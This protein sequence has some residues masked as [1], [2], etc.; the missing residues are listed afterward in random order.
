WSTGDT[1]ETTRYTT[2]VAND[3]VTLSVTSRVNGC[4]ADT[5]IAVT[6]RSRPTISTAPDTVICPGQSIVLPQ[7][8]LDNPALMMTDYEWQQVG[9]GVITSGAYSKTTP[10]PA[11]TVTPTDD[12]TYYIARLDGD[13][14]CGSAPDTM[15]VVVDV[16]KWT[17]SPAD[18]T[19]CYGAEVEII[20]K[21]LSGGDIRTMTNMPTFL[22][23][24]GAANG[25][26]IVT[27]L[28]DTM[29]IAYAKSEH[30]CDIFD[31]ARIHVYEIPE[32]S[33]TVDG[34]CSGNDVVVYASETDEAYEYAWTVSNGSA[35][36]A[37]PGDTLR[38]PSA[39]TDSVLNI[40]MQMTH[41]E[42]G[43]VY[44]VDTTLKLFV[45][46]EIPAMN[47]TVVC[48]NSMVRL[49]PS[50]NLYTAQKGYT[51]TWYD[52][53]LDAPLSTNA[54]G[55]FRHTYSNTY[56]REITHIATG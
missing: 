22:N 24:A 40:S 34:I 46:T 51:T 13:G 31:T 33:L 30:G 37:Q 48:Q 18:T 44:T 52:S 5:V 55:Q 36:Y 23:V 56:Y 49:F 32:V 45:M 42:A 21:T 43:C 54:Y 19:V 15:M 53:V 26:N 6:V 10:Q 35:L 7:I 4:T 47:D 8:R 17:I 20:I 28:Q 1:T 3:S 29:Y 41:K 12:T 9:V 16:P 25:H 14:I 2:W 38:Y 50:G 39:F 11:F 27:A